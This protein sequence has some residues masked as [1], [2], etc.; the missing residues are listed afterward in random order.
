MSKIRISY[1]STKRRWDNI[2]IGLSISKSRSWALLNIRLCHSNNLQHLEQ[3]L[4]Q[5]N[6]R[7]KV[8]TKKKR[9]ISFRMRSARPLLLKSQILSGAMLPVSRAPKKALRKLSSCLLNSHNFSR[10]LVNHGQVYCFMVHQERVRVSSPRLVLLSVTALSSQFH[11]RI[12]W[13]NGKVSLKDW[14]RIFLSS[15]EKGSHPWSLSMRLTRSAV[16]EPKVKM[17]PREESRPSSWFKWMVVE[18]VRREFWL[19]VLP[20][21]HGSWMR[22]SEEDSRKEFIFISPIS[23]LGP[24][25]LNSRFRTFQILYLKR[26]LFNWE[27]PQNSIP[28]LILRLYQKRH[29]SCQLENVRMLQNSN[30]SQMASGLPVHQVILRAKIWTC[31]IFQM[32]NWKS[33][34]YASTITCKLLLASNL[35][36]VLRISQGTKTLPINSVKMDDQFDWKNLVKR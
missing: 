19:W 18:I 2:L 30:K 27:P 15:P 17:N 32:E 11:L 1:K 4:L 26:T 35:Q 24:V 14:S 31:T 34:Q 13:V 20:I 7:R 25:C 22:P 10:V 16:R 12:S 9:K 28:V 8:A 21:L 3:V 29:F 5:L 33:H 36:Y 6:Q 23:K